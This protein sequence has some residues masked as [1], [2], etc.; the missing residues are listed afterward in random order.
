MVILEQSV[1]E[2]AKAIGE[3]PEDSKNRISTLPAPSF[4]NQALVSNI[5]LSLEDIQ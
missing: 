1:I 2:I 3:T 4:D 5:S